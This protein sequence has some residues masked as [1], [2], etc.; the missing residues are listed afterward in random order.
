MR[1]FAEGSW[2]SWSFYSRNLEMISLFL[3]FPLQRCE[4]Q[5]QLDADPQKEFKVRNSL[6]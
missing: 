4:A 1:K 3:T 5:T 6:N 2:K